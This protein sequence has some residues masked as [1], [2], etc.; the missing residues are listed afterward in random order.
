[1]IICDEVGGE[2]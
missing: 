1:M 2:N